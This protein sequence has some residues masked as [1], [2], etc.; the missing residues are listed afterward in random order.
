MRPGIL[1]AFAALGVPKTLHPKSPNGGLQG[2][3]NTLQFKYNQEP[4]EYYE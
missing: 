1:D 4:E 3:G 2:L